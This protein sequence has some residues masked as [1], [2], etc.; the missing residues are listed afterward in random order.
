MALLNRWSSPRIWFLAQSGH[1]TEFGKMTKPQKDGL[2]NLIANG[3]G[4]AGWH[5]HMGDAF[6]DR[7]T[8][9]S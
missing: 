5:G 2:L 1:R 8:I 9:T 7:P 6:R 4:I 3:C